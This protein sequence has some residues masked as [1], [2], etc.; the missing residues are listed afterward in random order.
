MKTRITLLAV[1]LVLAATEASAF[2]CG[3]R[4]TCIKTQGTQI[5]VDDVID[6]IDLCD[7]FVTN[8]TGR[9]VLHISLG[10]LMQ[11]SGGNPS[12]PLSRAHYAS[13][14]LHSSPL[15]FNRTE[16]R[17]QVKFNEMRQSCHQLQRDFDNNRLWV[18]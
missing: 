13:E 17:P 15:V 4:T 16:S 5:P 2:F 10:E 3:F 7:D 11:R 18:K 8:G 12:H 14:K 6:M 1:G 9:I